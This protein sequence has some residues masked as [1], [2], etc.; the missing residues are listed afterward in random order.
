MTKFFQPSK[1]IQTE[2][3]ETLKNRYQDAVNPSINYDNKLQNIS[4]TVTYYSQHGSVTALFEYRERPSP[5][6]RDGYWYCRQD[7]ND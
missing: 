7:W 1:S 2:L 5:S 6:D 3:N 4:A